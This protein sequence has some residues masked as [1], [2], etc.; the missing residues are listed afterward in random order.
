MNRFAS[1]RSTIFALLLLAAFSRCA[2]K[3]VDENDPGELYKEA[4]EEISSDHYQLAIDKLRSVK[5]R[6]PYSKYATDA[7]LRIA[8]VYY[9]QE[10]Y[11]EAALSYESFRDLHPKHEKTPYAMFRIG[12]SYFSDIPANIARDLTPAYRAQ[13]AFKEYL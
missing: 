9:L 4:E 13:D 1:A 10:L 7:Q 6:F 11:A 8:D 3:T 12:K 2:G 5:N